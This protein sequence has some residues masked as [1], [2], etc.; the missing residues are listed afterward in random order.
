M[1]GQGPLVS[2]RIGVVGYGTVAAADC[3]MAQ[4]IRAGSRHPFTIAVPDY[5]ALFK[6]IQALGANVWSRTFGIEMGG[7]LFSVGFQ[8]HSG[9]QGHT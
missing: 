9:S 2:G 3:P 7:R 1:A 6:T 4:R 5:P 8:P